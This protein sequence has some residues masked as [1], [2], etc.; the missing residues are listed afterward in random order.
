MAGPAG[1]TRC[2]DMW[3]ID[4]QQIADEVFAR[5]EHGDDEHRKWLRDHL[6]NW[7]D[8]REAAGGDWNYLNFDPKEESDGR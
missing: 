2:A 3:K 7:A 8:N 5:I 6:I 4:W 1:R